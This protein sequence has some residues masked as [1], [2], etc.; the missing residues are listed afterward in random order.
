VAPTGAPVR[1][2]AHNNYN[3]PM[4]VYADGAGTRF[5]LGLVQP[6][7]TET[8]TIPANVVS[9]GSVELLAQLIAGRSKIARTGPLLLSPG[10]VVDFVITAQLFDSYGAV[11]PQ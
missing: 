11:R 1:V 3:G 6:A 9:I 10:A 7:T 4:E 2:V 8:F 5:R